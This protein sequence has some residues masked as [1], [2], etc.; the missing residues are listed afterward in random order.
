MVVS[1]TFPDIDKVPEERVVSIEDK[2]L[3]VPNPERFELTP[4]NFECVVVSLK[5]PETDNTPLKELSILVKSE[6]PLSNFVCVN[7]SLTV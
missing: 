6:F 1:L 5:L 2:V 3:S 4:S 7:V